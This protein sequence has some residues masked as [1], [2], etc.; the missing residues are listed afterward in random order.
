MLDPRWPVVRAALDRLAPRYLDVLRALVAFPSIVG[1]ERPAQRYL[2]DVA[3]DAGLRTELYDVAPQALQSDPR[4]GLADLGHGTRPNLVATAPGSGGG[5]SLLLSG[6]VDVVPLGERDAWTVDPFG[7]QVV[8]GRLY[9]RGALDMK[10]GLVAALHAVAALASSGVPLR[11]DLAFESV[12]EEEATGNG[13]L[14]ARLRG[15]GA[16]AAIIPELSNEAMLIATPG[17]LWAEITTTG[18]SAYVGRSGAAVNAIDVM[19]EVLAGLRSLPASLNAGWSHPAYPADPPPL[20]LNVG[21]I[22]GGD[23]PSSVPLAC[24]AGIRFSF[25]IGWPVERAKAALTERLTEI[26]AAHPW[27]REHPPAIRWHGF[28]AT[29]W[30]IAPDAPIVAAVRDAYRD[31]TGGPA[32]AAPLYGTADARFFRDAGIPAVYLGPSGDGQHGPDEWVDLAS[33]ARVTRTLARAALAWCG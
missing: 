24:R 14:A 33:V 12:I 4:A 15:P 10:G 17:V 31:E 21:T 26:A 18:R 6:H 16:D 30:D 8:D 9:G 29:G 5:R 19:L 32:A 1:D 3:A 11:G 22:A 28:Q 23:W 7:A 2:R 27:L 20:T 13:A 25:P